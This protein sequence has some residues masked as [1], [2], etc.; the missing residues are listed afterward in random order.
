M[1]KYPKIYL[2]SASPR[3]HELLLQIGVVHEVLAVPP[4]PGEDEPRLA[5]EAPIDYVRRTALDKAIWAQTWLSD[6]VRNQTKQA[7]PILAA[8]TT[9]AL[10]GLVLGKPIDAID[11]EHMLTQ[12]SGRTHQVFTAVALMTDTG[13]KQ[14]LS[15]SDVTFSKLSQQNIENYIRTGEPFGKAGGYG[16]QGFA[17][18]FISSLNGSYSGVMGLPL[19]ETFSLLS[20]DS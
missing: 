17:G 12:L 10:G 7:Y 16:I 5:G 8:D 11:A 20:A 13:I 6:Q 19:H 9:V 1:Y 18:A 4:P 2:A 3:R 14:A 15:V